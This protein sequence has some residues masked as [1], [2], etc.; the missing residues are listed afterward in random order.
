[1]PLNGIF[2]PNGRYRGEHA[3]VLHPP[4]ASQK[5]LILVILAKASCYSIPAEPST[6]S[7]GRF[8]AIAK[9]LVSSDQG[10]A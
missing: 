8:A 6:D 1:M 7:S 4:P 5:V 9:F 10:I 2:G 3:A